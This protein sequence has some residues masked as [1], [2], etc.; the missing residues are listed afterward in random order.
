M[1]SP[2]LKELVTEQI[3][4]EFGGASRAKAKRNLLDQLDDKHDFDL[5]PKMVDQEFGQIWQQLQAEMDAGGPLA[6]LT[7]RVHHALRGGP[8]RRPKSRGSRVTTLPFS[9]VAPLRS[10]FLFDIVCSIVFSIVF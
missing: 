5:P 7:E 10:S 3:Q 4:N 8:P 2:K 6:G 1:N 9:L